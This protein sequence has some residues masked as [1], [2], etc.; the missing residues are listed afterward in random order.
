M[1][2]E[3]RAILRR[4]CTAEGHLHAVIIMLKTGKPGDEVLHQL[5]AVQSALRLAGYALA[6]HQ[7]KRSLEA[8]LCAP[9][10]E[11]RQTELDKLKDL[12]RWLTRAP[13]FIQEEN[14]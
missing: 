7:V 6:R 12:Y 9:C 8:I 3:E 1:S 13:I 11:E 4:L 2:P 14:L 5:G 10:E